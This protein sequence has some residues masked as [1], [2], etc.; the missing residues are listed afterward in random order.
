MFV[1]G[2]RA[3]MALLVCTS[4]ANL[5]A[6]RSSLA[7]G[8]I[9]VTLLGTAGGPPAHVGIAGISTLIEAGDDHLL[10]DAGRGV[11][12]RL[13]QTR[14]RMEAVSKLFLTHLH[15]D[16]VMDIP[17]LLLTPW[18]SPTAP[19]RVPFEVWG[20]EGTRD[21]MAHLEQAFAFDIHVRRDVDDHHSP[22]GIQVVAR[23]VSEGIVYAKNGVT[24]T[25]FLVD[26]EPVKPSYGYRVDFGGR[27]VCLSGDTR[28][29]ENLVQACRGVDVLIHEAIDQEALRKTVPSQEL[30][31]A[32]VG[33]HTTPE[34][35]ADVFRRVGPRLA[36]FSHVAPPAADLDRVRRTYSGRVEKGEDLMVIDIGAEIIVRHPSPA[37]A[38]R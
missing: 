17:D 15:S 1:G 37:P 5:R 20:P 7:G 23:D 8:Q 25:A 19:R 12:Q 27:S 18:S 21:M 26:H 24:I 28:P 16:H 29:S 30:F 4:A 31:E 13:V 3:I 14:L 32:I 6:Q 2:R 35:A 33:H 11:M 36:V 10:F 34:Q 9:R 22:S 38:P